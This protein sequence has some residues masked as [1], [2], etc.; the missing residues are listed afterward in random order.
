MSSTTKILLGLA[1]AL[2]VVIGVAAV[3]KGDRE[4]GTAVDVAAAETRAITQ[5]VVASG[6]VAPEVEVKIASDVSGEIVRLMVE[7]G[8]RVEQGQLLVQVQ[9]E[10]YASQRDQSTASLRQAEADLA[11]AEAERSRSETDLERAE[12]LFAQGVVARSEVEAARTAAAVAAANAQA[13]EFRVR[14][15]RATL[16]QSSQQLAR[17]SIYAP[18][19]GT[20]SQLNVELGERVVGTAQMTGTEILRIAELDQM[21]LEVEINENDVVNV[22]LGDTAKVGVDAYL[23]RPLQGVVTKIAN[24]ARVTGAGSAEQVTNFPVEVKITSAHNLS[25]RLAGGADAGTTEASEIAE[26]RPVPPGGA[27]QLR[28]GMSG[29]VDIFTETVPGAVVVPIQAVTVR[30]FNQVQPGLGEPETEEDEEGEEDDAPPPAVGQPEDLRRV[31]FVMR[32][33]KA[34]MVEVQTGISDDT[35]I[36]VRSGLAGGETVITGPFRLLRTD[37]KPGQTVRESSGMGEEG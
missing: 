33:G 32:D 11:R 34:E 2:V 4:V 20:V 17:T 26:A 18:I 5:T 29:T 30:D 21:M 9:P 1:V 25:G 6:R 23:E 10:F 37:L 24:S 36:E 12:G 16:Q 15:A 27:P 28:P 14:S 19:G 22:T 7:E 31:V 3:F 35:H 13:A 8:D